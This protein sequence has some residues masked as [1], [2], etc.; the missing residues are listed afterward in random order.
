MNLNMDNKLNKQLKKIITSEESQQAKDE[1][2]SQVFLLAMKLKRNK[3]T[4]STAPT[5]TQATKLKPTVPTPVSPNGNSKR[6]VLVEFR[7]SFSLFPRT[8]RTWRMHVDTSRTVHQL[9]IQVNIELKHTSDPTFR[10]IVSHTFVFVIFIYSPLVRQSPTRT[11]FLL[12]KQRATD[13]RRS[14]QVQFTRWQ[15]N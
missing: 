7:A 6:I 8:T 11:C 15:Y 10:L 12:E 14:G 4:K 13:G 3:V 1:V 2:R 9:M 5:P